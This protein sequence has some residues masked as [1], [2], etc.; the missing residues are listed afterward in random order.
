[1]K[2]MLPAGAVGTGIFLLLLSG[3]WGFLF[4]ATSSWTDEKAE[5]MAGLTKEVHSL[6]FKSVGAKEQRGSQRGADPKAAEAEYERAK[7]EL[8]TLR[9]EFESA[10]DSPTTAANYLRWVGTALVL[11]GGLGVMAGRA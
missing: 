7:E 1:M 3:V 2:E 11:L 4:P 8:A 9:E 5:R 6:L 10:R